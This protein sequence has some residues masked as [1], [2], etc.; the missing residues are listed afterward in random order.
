MPSHSSD[1]R[2]LPPNAEYAEAFRPAPQE[3]HPGHSQMLKAAEVAAMLGISKR[4]LYRMIQRE[5]IPGPVKFGRCS[6]WPAQLLDEL[7][8]RWA[9]EC[10]AGLRNFKA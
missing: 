6:G 1:E 3:R 9:R 8:R 4:H 2:R 10:L 5:V 7:Q